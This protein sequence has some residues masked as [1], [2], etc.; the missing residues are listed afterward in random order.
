MSLPSGAKTFL[1]SDCSMSLLCRGPDSALRPD[2]K[3]LTVEINKLD[4]DTPNLSGSGQSQRKEPDT[5]SQ[6][7]KPG[8]IKSLKSI[9]HT[10][11]TIAIQINRSPEEEKLL[12]SGKL[13]YARVHLQE[14]IPIS[15][16]Q[17]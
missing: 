14:Y 15:H 6:E 2:V 9:L 1:S 17:K 3:E 4:T 8:Q 11:F 12:V 7:R 16:L 13:I 5:E 10:Y